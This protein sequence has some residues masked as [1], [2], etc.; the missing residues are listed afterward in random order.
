MKFSDIVSFKFSLYVDVMTNST[1]NQHAIMVFMIRIQ[2][3][4]FNYQYQHC[5]LNYIIVETLIKK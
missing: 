4:T 2:V 1:W 5:Q 3:K